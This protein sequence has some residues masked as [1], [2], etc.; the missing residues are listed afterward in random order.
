MPS[1]SELVVK[2]GMKQELAVARA[3][4]R[5][6]IPIISGAGLSVDALDPLVPKETKAIISFGLCGGLA[7]LARIGQAF[8]YSAVKTPNGSIACDDAWV[9]RLFAATRYFVSACWSS[10]ELN[11]ANTIAQRAEL[12][13]DSG[14]SIIDDE[15]RAVAELAAR[16]GIRFAGLRVISD[17][18]EDSLPPAVINALNPDG[19]DNIWNVIESLFTEP[20]DPVTKEF[21]IGE[22]VRT[23]REFNVSIA[24]LRTAALAAGKD[25]QWT[26]L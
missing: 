3:Y 18:A 8:I 15:S 25:F 2:V 7:P 16:R 24:E 13:R 23:I 9:K 22:I 17:G 1:S 6:G 14:C 12:Y 19:T 11:T 5:P 26:N 21:Q 10:G 20:I 4:A